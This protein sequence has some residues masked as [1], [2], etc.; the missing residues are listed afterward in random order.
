M[1]TTKVST[2]RKRCFLVLRQAITGSQGLRSRGRYNHTHMQAH[3][4]TKKK[5]INQLAQ[6]I[7]PVAK[8]VH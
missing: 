3:P 6:D 5:K 4:L 1:S 8:I 2:D 7:V